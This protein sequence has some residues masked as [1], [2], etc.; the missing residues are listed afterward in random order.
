MHENVLLTDPLNLRDVCKLT[1]MPLTQER[2]AA[3]QA[4]E[5]YCC[6]LNLTLDI[7]SA[8]TSLANGAL[9][10]LTKQATA[11]GPQIVGMITCMLCA[12]KIESDIIGKQK[13]R[14]SFQPTT[15]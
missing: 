1:T 14:M 8:E 4:V 11:N 7:G 12:Q 10:A 9:Q 3:T 15:L 6:Q 5:R 2:V 13:Q